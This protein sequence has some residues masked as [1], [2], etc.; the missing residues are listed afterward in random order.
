MATFQILLDQLDKQQ[1]LNIETF[2]KNGI[3]VKTPVWFVLEGDALYIQTETD[4]GKAK[5]IRRNGQVKV[6]PCKMDGA[7]LG[8]W[9]PAI[10]R[11]VIDTEVINKIDRLFGE[12][13]GLL[14]GI[15]ALGAVL[16]R[17]KYAVLEIKGREE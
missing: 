9:Q 1:Y 2:R 5:R 12:K 7:L 10:A 3:G 4:S 11:D 6:A 14:K 8:D 17:K 13:Y 15:F 16:L